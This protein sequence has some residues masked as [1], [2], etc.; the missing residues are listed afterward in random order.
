MASNAELIAQVYVGFYDRA[1]DPVGLQ[2]WMGRLEAG[3][4]I[5]DIGD[6]FAASPEASETYPFFKFPGLLSP[7]DFLGEVYQNVFGRP[8]DADGLAYYSGRMAAGE[9]AGSV[10]ASILGN[11][12][13]NE[14]SPDQAFL[15]N[16]VDAGLYWAQ[17]AAVTN[18]NIYKENGRL[19]DQA[20]ISSHGVIDGVNEDPT[21]VDAAKAEANAFFAGGG[22]DGATFT[23]TPGTDF[24][25]VDGSGRGGPDWLP[26]TG[27]KFTSK[28]ETVNA[29]QATIAGG[30]S[31]LD[32][33]TS[34][35]D[36]FNLSLSG[37]AA[38]V[39]PTMQNIENINVK[40]NQFSGGSIDFG[41]V[42]GSRTLD[43]DGSLNGFLTLA[44]ITNS[45]ITKVD[46]SGLTSI[47]AG[48]GFDVDFSG[49]F[50]TVAHEV[51]GSGADDSIIGGNGADKLSGGAGDD[52]IVG[53][54]GNDI[55]DGGDGA[56]LINGG[57]G[58]DTITGGAGNDTL[59]GDD[60]NDTIDGGAG[61]DIINGG[62]GNDTITGGAGNDTID[63]GTGDDTIDGGAGNDIIDSGAGNNKVTG[64]DG[65]DTITLSGSHDTLVFSAENG[66]DTVNGFE[67]GG[68]GVANGG[69]TMDFSAFLGGAANVSFTVVGAAGANA[70]DSN[71]VLVD[72][73][74]VTD[75]ATLQ[76]FISAAAGD[77]NL[78]LDARTVVLINDGANA[79]A[80]YVTTNGLG[81]ATDV[82]QVATIGGVD[83]NMLIAYNFA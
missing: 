52:F 7:N 12:A 64:G 55:L 32:D 39:L 37:A 62:A 29:N 82:T 40:L 46:G 80:Y 71:V 81:E 74:A 22:S 17:Q 2:Y 16:K 73:G 83:V 23:L 69:D 31:L 56:D 61:N 50:G 59:N 18:A 10:V 53:G 5:Q 65:N 27:F 54:S 43:L 70:M 36:K 25:D 8:I 42:A 51:I 49:V 34:D 24:A 41:T 45:G 79:E 11:A 60:G 13:S 28:S 3:V 14:G 38:A 20:N 68:A 63:G 67:V 35:Q 19:T 66:E 75:A 48:N 33:Y 6:S 72:N 58:N 15:Q 47:I 76:T 21:T 44:N 78:A 26:D 30:D 9:S 1:P 4:S 57:T 77:L